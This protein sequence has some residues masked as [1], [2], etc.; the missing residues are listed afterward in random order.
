[1]PRHTVECSKCH[2]VIEDHFCSPWPSHLPHGCGGELEI[3]WTPSHRFDASAHPWE[4]TVVY[5]SPDGKVSYP[6]RNDQE[7]PKRYRDAGYQR[8]EFEHAREVEKFEK[9]HNVCCEKLWF[10]SGNGV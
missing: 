8:V 5:I 4:R 1:M 10:N 2:E 9:A 6:P 3:L 7:M